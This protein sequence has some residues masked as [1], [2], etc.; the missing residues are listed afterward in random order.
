MELIGV[1]L[2]CPNMFEDAKALLEYGFDNYETAVMAKKG[3]TIVRATVKG[4]E[5]SILELTPLQDIIVPVE[6]GASASF[7]TRVFI[8]ESISAPVYK[9]DVLG[10][11]EVLDG[12][13]LLLRCELVAAEDVPDAGISYY[14]DRIIRR[15]AA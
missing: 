10:S 14:F 3:T 15:F 8:D 13:A 6:K 9:G 5:K 7:R 12:D 11:V 2:N 1:V 4:G